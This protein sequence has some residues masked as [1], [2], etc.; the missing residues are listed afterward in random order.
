[1]IRFIR[2]E[3][4][5][6]DGDAM[7]IDTPGGIGY[8]VF[9]PET[10]PLLNKKE[11]D[12]VTINTFLQVKEDGMQLYGFPDTESLELFEKLITVKGVGPKAGL[13][14]MALA[15]CEVIKQYIVAKD[16]SFVSRASGIGKKIAER[17]ILELCD[18]LDVINID[19]RGTSGADSGLNSMGMKSSEREEAVIALTTLGYSKSEAND[20]IMKVKEEGLSAEDYVRNALKYLM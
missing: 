17:V 10:S 14:I 2:G 11:G 3:Y 20:A 7:I 8:R 9:V 4:L 12:T 19:M 13:S 16:A 1:M 18:K 6:Y 15:E 5:Y